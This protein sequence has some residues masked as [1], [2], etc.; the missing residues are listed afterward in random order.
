ML[1]VEIGLFLVIAFAAAAADYGL[2]SQARYLRGVRH[3]YRQPENLSVPAAPDVEAAGQRGLRVSRPP[4]AGG[5]SRRERKEGVSHESSRLPL[6]A[7]SMPQA[8]GLRSLPGAPSIRQTEA[9]LRAGTEAGGEGRS[10]PPPER[11]VNRL[12]N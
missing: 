4:G 10:F 2:Y 8:W 7:A 11:K 9:A 6:Q 12:W 3:L 1:R 5:I